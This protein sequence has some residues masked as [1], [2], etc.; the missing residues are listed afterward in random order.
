M[1]VIRPHPRF[2]ALVATLMVA[3]HCQAASFIVNNTQDVPDDNPGNGICHPVNGAANTCTLRAAIMEANALPGSHQIALPSGQY[4]PNRPGREEQAALTGDLDISRDITIVNGT[5]NPPIIFSITQDRVFDILS[6]GSLTL[7]NIGVNG[8]VA[9]AVGTVRG[10]AFQVT[11]GA[12]LFLD[13]A[14]VGTN[15]A[16]IGGAIYSDG[17][18]DIVDSEFYNNAIT[19]DNVQLE[20]ASGAA[21]FSRGQLNVERSTFRENGNIPGAESLNLITSAYAIHTKNSGPASPSSTFVNTTIA[22]NTRGVRSEGVALQMDMVTIAGNS[23]IGLRFVADIGNLG[24]PQLKLRQTVIADNASTNCNGIDGDA[25]ESAVRNRYNAST[26]ASCGFTGGNDFQNIES[27]FFGPLGNYGGK[28]P[29]LI[30]HFNSEIVDAGGPLCLPSFEDQRGKLRPM[31]GNLDAD[32]GCDIG[33]VEFDPLNDPISNDVI[34][35]DG[36]ESATP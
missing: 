16:N 4:T 1:T 6:G 2:F 7:R 5:N 24:V 8:G 9:N 10:G 32:N 15:Y 36:F 26:D 19:A 14:K 30:P 35:A 12:Q 11:T 34:F 3:G 18:V 22:N 23:G 33:A 31:D 25:A 28:T 27:P 29:V 20:F 13:R 17:L 21:I